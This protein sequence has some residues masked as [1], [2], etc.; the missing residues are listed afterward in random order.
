MSYTLRPEPHE[1]RE[2]RQK[3]EGV[4]EACKYILEKDEV[5]ELS[6]GA[7]PSSPESKHGAQGFA[8]GPATAQLYIRPEKDSWKED[9]EKVAYKVYGK[10]WF[11]EKT[12]DSGLVWREI[13]AESLGLMFLEK[14]LDGRR[15]EAGAEE[16]SEEWKDLKDVLAEFLSEGV[17][18]EYSWQLKWYLGEALSERYSFSEFTELRKSDIVEA[19]EEVFE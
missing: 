13:L 9:L 6:I 16:F 8:S 5:L 2:A 17:Q 1:I 7:A 4:M 15:P 18:L 10:S 12:E 3:V 11:Y 14:Q 19:G